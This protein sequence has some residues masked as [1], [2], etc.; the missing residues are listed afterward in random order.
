MYAGKIYLE[1]V[2]PDSE[3]ILV[4]PIEPDIDIGEDDNAQDESPLEFS[5]D[6]DFNDALMDEMVENDLSLVSNSASSGS[7]Y[8]FGQEELENSERKK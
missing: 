1:A 7:F 8:G 5:K 6:M 3:E 2:N 4:V